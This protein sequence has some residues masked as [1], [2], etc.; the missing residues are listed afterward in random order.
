VADT[1]DEGDEAGE[2]VGDGVEISGNSLWLRRCFSL[3]WRR[4]NSCFF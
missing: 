1:E 2:I 3:G 4:G